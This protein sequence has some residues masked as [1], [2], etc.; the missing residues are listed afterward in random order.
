MIF[1][2]SGALVFAC[3]MFGFASL[4]SAEEHGA[5][6]ATSEY[7]QQLDAEPTNLIAS[8]L[9]V[10]QPATH[11]V[12]ITAENQG[13]H[14]R[15]D[16][17]TN[18]PDQPQQ[19]IEKKGVGTRATDLFTIRFVKDGA[20][21]KGSISLDR[22]GKYSAKGTLTLED[23]VAVHL[24]CQL[25]ADRVFP[26]RFDGF[27]LTNC[28]R[29]QEAVVGKID[30]KEGTRATSIVIEKGVKIAPGA[31]HKFDTAVDQYSSMTVWSNLGRRGCFRFSPFDNA[32][33]E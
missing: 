17:Q 21:E 2:K 29:H 10:T 26:H 23:N 16:R 3:T 33:Q 1:K 32:P 4:S 15:I 22:T 13:Y 8:C 28:S 12:T 7:A 30:I 24:T 31:R 27:Y 18:N 20:Y 9:S 5:V 6:A 25:F 19:R 11:G 14:V